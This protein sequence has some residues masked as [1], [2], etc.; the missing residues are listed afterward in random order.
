MVVNRQSESIPVCALS[1]LHMHRGMLDQCSP[2]VRLRNLKVFSCLGPRPR[3]CVQVALLPILSGIAQTPL[4][5]TCQR[6]IQLWLL[7]YCYPGSAW[8]GQK[9]SMR[10]LIRP[11]S[12]FEKDDPLLLTAWLLV[13]EITYRQESSVKPHWAL[14][15]RSVVRRKQLKRRLLRILSQ[16]IFGF[17]FSTH[18][19]EA[20]CL[21]RIVKSESEA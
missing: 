2:K 17:S 7:V 21:L 14:A 11:G 9:D 20:C 3:L 6:E 18:T 16:P 4:S 8:E 15:W 13:L 10:P 19:I 5:M 12:L 1:P